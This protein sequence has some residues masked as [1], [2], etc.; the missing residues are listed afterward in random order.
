MAYYDEW[1]DE[2]K[3]ELIDAG[4]TFSDTGVPLSGLNVAVQ[5]VEGAYDEETDTGFTATGTGSFLATVNEDYRSQSEATESDAYAEF[6]AGLQATERGRAAL[7]TWGGLELWNQQQRGIQEGYSLF[8]EDN[9]LTGRR[10]TNLNLNPDGSTGVGGDDVR[11]KMQSAFYAALRQAGMDKTTID[12]L[13]I[14]AEDQW[15]NDPSFTAERALIGMYD[16]QAF[17]DRFP[18]IDQMTQGGVGRRDLPT[19]GEY[20]RFEKYVASELSRVGII[21]TDFD[22]LIAKLYVN[23]VGDAEV[24]ERL[25]TAQQVMWEMP[26]EV[27]DTFTDW[28]GSQYGT[29]ITMKT[30]LDNTGDW[31]KIQDDITTAR[32]GGWGRMVAGLDAGWDKDLAKKVSDLGLSQ[33]EQWSRFAELKE[34]EMLFAENIDEAVDLDYAEHGVAAEF[35]LD[36]D[37]AEIIDRRATGRSARFSGAGGAVMSGTTTGFGAA[38]A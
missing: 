34:K 24:T 26:Q 33:A 6:I 3:Q 2:Y 9:D 18:G 8:A 13:W 35:D 36:I 15:K 14:W 12:A 28:F 1:S 37:L 23:S 7:A 27:R 29:S 11:A 30:F 25:N 22:A 19:P 31:S 17:K 20:I 38:N 16:H 4:A 32:T 21:E 5:T 10:N